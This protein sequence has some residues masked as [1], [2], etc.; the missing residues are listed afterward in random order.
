[1]QESETKLCGGASAAA[2]IVVTVH[3]SLVNAQCGILIQEPA[4]IG[5]DVGS[6]RCKLL[7]DMDGAGPLP[8]ELLIGT[9]KGRV[10]AYNGTRFRQFGP[11]MVESGLTYADPSDPSVFHLFNFR[12][13][14]HAVSAGYR[15]DSQGS[16]FR[17]N[18][19]AWAAIPRAG[20]CGAGTVTG[21]FLGATIHNDEIIVV[22]QNLRCG[23]QNATAL[24]WNGSSWRRV[25]DAPF[26]TTSVY[27]AA[28][29]TSDGR[30]L[31]GGSI[32]RSLPAQNLLLA[33][34]VG[35]LWQ[36]LLLGTSGYSGIPVGRFQEISDQLIVCG[37][38][39]TSGIEPPKLL[40]KETAGAW[41][42]WEPFNAGV[43]PPRM[44]VSNEV[45]ADGDRTI[46]VG[47][48]AGSGQ[49]AIVV[50]E[51]GQSTR[52]I[53]P[54]NGARR[55]TGG[56]ERY[57]DKYL[58]LGGTPTASNICT[59]APGLLFASVDDPLTWRPI[60]SLLSSTTAARTTLGAVAAAEGVIMSAKGTQQTPIGVL[61]PNDCIVEFSN[62]ARRDGPEWR[63]PV[64]RLNNQVTKLLRYN[65]EVVALGDFTL[66]G[67]RAVTRGI[68]R[69]DGNAWQSF[70][71][72]PVPAATVNQT[73]VV[74]QGGLVVADNPGGWRIR[75]FDG[76]AWTQLGAN[77]P[78]GTT[79][80]F[81]ASN[82]A[83]L[84]FANSNRV[85]EWDGSSWLRLG[86]DANTPVVQSLTVFGDTVVIG[87][88]AVAAASVY[89]W[90]DAQWT[91]LGTFAPGGGRPSFNVLLEH[92]GTLFGGARGPLL[93]PQAPLM[94]LSGEN[95]VAA[96]PNPGAIHGSDPASLQTVHDLFSDGDT[97]HIA[98]EFIQ[99]GG[100]PFEGY[101]SLYSGP[102]R[103][104]TQPM[105]ASVAHGLDAY[106]S[107]DPEVHHDPTQTYRWRRD[108]Q[109]LHDGP[110]GSGSMIA[111]ATTPYLR[112]SIVSAADAG[113][114]AV[115]VVNGC[116]ETLSSSASLNIRCPA[117]FDDGTGTGMPD[118]GVTIDDLL[119]YIGLFDV[120]AVAADLDDGSATGTRD[121][122][123][124]IDDLLYFLAR[125]EN[126]C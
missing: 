48:I 125:F 60:S 120:G 81:L 110:T 19:S 123:V 44:E 97:L 63:F 106:F 53:L 46:T 61:R 107:I 102:P 122:G 84:I 54:Y 109:D 73:G 11:R 8:P 4:T 116:G 88:T 113:T 66:A 33:E 35:D 9:D 42:P 114:Y 82:G 69:W 27:G 118:G 49:G 45:L 74:W 18:G 85:Y 75:R 38:L 86:T 65:N 30:L 90:D 83:R 103:I 20:G 2:L 126:G 72:A 99:L 5:Q 40:M 17:W 12:G 117:D 52:V 21:W 25:G 23:N 39:S 68:A 58:A 29:G 10:F 64:E 41:T 121:G 28:Y 105:D 92:H 89:R 101:A 32:A 22:G 47:G 43:A 87:A 79:A 78:A 55:I 37:S 26:F 31:I 62:T 1:M 14:L 36:T 108:G 6:Y 96:V 24:A 13:E 94:R 124:T 56:V 98:G 71:V 111:G 76:T 59:H 95:W 100:F 93:A 77:I 57:G 70:P 50:F 51:N 115:R 91:P 15:S 119:F 7:H 112:I 80:A 3:A 16:I 67:T 34:L 104:L